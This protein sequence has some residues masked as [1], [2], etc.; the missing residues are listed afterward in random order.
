MAQEV[1]GILPPYPYVSVPV[2]LGTV[3]GVMMI[4]GGIGM[5]LLKRRADPEPASPPAQALDRTFLFVL[6]ALNATGLVLLPFRETPLMGI[7][8]DVHLALVFAFLITAP[9]GKL[10]HG[11]YRYAALVLDRLEARAETAPHGT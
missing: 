2:V 7:L 5:L 8:L 3:G 10:V 6:I 11:A 4:A 9:Y 1:L